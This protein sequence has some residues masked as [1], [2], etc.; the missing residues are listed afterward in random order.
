MD[1]KRV[2][3]LFSRW[4]EADEDTSSIG[5]AYSKN[6]GTRY[7]TCSTNRRMLLVS[8]SHFDNKFVSKE[9]PIGDAYAYLRKK[10][11]VTIPF[12]HPYLFKEKEM[13]IYK[14][15]LDIA[16]SALPEGEELVTITRARKGFL[17]YLLAI[18]DNSLVILR[19]RRKSREVLDAQSY[20]LSELKEL[21]LLYGKKRVVME[22]PYENNFNLRLKVVTADKRVELYGIVTIDGWG[23]TAA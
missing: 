1:E 10:G 5:K 17:S 8:W 16:L 7:Y 21:S 23:G 13:A 20:R 12:D 11:I 3:T 19:K 9:V 22:V 4:L 2:R 6:W 14:G 15:L 18:S